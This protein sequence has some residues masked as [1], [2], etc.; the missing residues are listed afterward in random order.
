MEIGRRT[1]DPKN[2]GPPPQPPP[3][4]QKPVIPT[5][6]NLVLSNTSY[7]HYLCVAQD[8]PSVNDH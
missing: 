1:V 4:S 3:Q 2:R 6:S 8:A 7:F 5:V